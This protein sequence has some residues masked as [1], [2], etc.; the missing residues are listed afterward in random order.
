MGEEEKHRDVGWQVR[1]PHKIRARTWSIYFLGFDLLTLM[2]R[3]QTYLETLIPEVEKNVEGRR[4]MVEGED[5][6]GDETVKNDKD[7]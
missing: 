2:N 1:L 6:S 7:A 5:D 4:V 3:D